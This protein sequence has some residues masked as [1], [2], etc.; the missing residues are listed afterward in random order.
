MTNIDRAAEVLWENAGRLVFGTSAAEHGGWDDLSGT[1]RLPFT[2]AARALD[3]A[4]LLMPDHPEPGHDK[5]TGTGNGDVHIRWVVDDMHLTPNEARA[6]G[7]DL[8]AAADEAE[9]NSHEL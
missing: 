4:G 9:G 6:L 8:L 2:S 5:W 3:A 7:L 1:A